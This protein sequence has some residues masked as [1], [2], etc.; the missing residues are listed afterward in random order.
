MA[1]NKSN[2]FD[3]I[4]DNIDKEIFNDIVKTKKLRIERI[5]SKGQ[6]SPD[7]GWYD[8]DENEWVMVIEGCGVIAFFDGSKIKLNKGDYVNIPKHT[9]HKVIWTDTNNI[10]LWLAIF[11]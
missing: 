11:Y 9:K 6:T 3:K 8:Q 1:E 7:S 10:T 5:I 4:P 2:I